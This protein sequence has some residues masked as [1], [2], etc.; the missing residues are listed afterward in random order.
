MVCAQFVLPVLYYIVEQNVLL[1]VVFKYIE[2]NRIPF[3]FVIGTVCN[4]TTPGTRL[5]YIQV[6]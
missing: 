1:Y 3:H 6:V 4:N 5:N 2:K